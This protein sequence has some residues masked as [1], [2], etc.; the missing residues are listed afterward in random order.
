MLKNLTMIRFDDLYFFYGEL[1]KIFVLKIQCVSYGV[2]GP[3]DHSVFLGV[4]Y[5]CLYS[6]TKWKSVQF[7]EVNGFSIAIPDIEG[8]GERLNSTLI[9]FIFIYYLSILFLP[10]L[11]ILFWFHLLKYFHILFYKYF[12][13]HFLGGESNK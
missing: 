8:F 13:L 11:S 9:I 3:P 12:K 4:L 6:T 2:S 1:I 10:L 7:C 5:C